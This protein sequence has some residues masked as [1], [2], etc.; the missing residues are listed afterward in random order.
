MG[1]LKHPSRTLPVAN[2]VQ[3]TKSLYGS[4][5]PVWYGRTRGPL[6]LIWTGNFQK[7]KQGKKGK[8]G[9]IYTA[10]FD[11]LLGYGPMQGIGAQFINTAYFEGFP[12]SQSFLTG[13]GTTFTFTITNTPAGWDLA[14]VIG[15][16]ASLPF[17][18][19]YN[20]YGGPG[21][22]ASS[23]NSATPLPNQLFPAPNSGDWQFGNVPYSQYNN[24]LNSPT[25]VVTFPSSVSNVN[26]TAYYLYGVREIDG[27]NS[28]LDNTIF[29]PKLGSG[30]E[31]APIVY[32]DFSGVGT[33]D[34][35]MGNAAVLPNLSYEGY[36]LFS[37]GAKG[38]A[39]PA[40]VVADLICSGNNLA[41]PI[42]NGVSVPVWQ[43][44]LNF[45]R[46]TAP[47]VA[48]QN[49]AYARY[50]GILDDEPNIWGPTFGGGSSVG[51]SLFRAFCQAYGIVISNVLTIQSPGAQVLDAI[52]ELT[53]TAACWDGAQLKIIPYCEVSQYGNGASYVSPTAS[54]PI[55]TFTDA[56]YLRDKDKN[57]K[58]PVECV[59]SRPASDFNSLT[60][61]YTDRVTGN[62]NPLSQ[63]SYNSN[64]VLVADQ[65]DITIQGPMPGTSKD[66]KWIHDID[67][68]TH[69]GQALIRR[70]VLVGRRKYTWKTSGKFGLLSLL[71]LTLLTE[72]SF[73]NSPFPVRLTKIKQNE[74]YSM[75]FEAESFIYGASAPIPIASITPASGQGTPPIDQT[76]LPGSV[77]VPIIFEAVPAI[78][79]R[80]QI[81]LCTSGASVNYGGCSIWLST[82]GGSTYVK[83]GQVTDS[84]TQGFVYSSNYPSHADPDAV[85]TLNVDLTESLG[86]MDSFSTA[87]RDA[88]LSLCYLEGGGTVNAN[89]QTLTIPYELIAYATANLSALHKYALVPTNR[90]G[91]FGTPIAAHN[92]GSDFS[93][94][95]D[96]QVFM[97]DMLQA[98]IG[99]TLHFKFTAYNPFGLMEE[100]LSVVADYTFTPTGTVG[101]TYSAGGTPVGTQPFPTGGVNPS[102]PANM[103][104]DLYCYVPGIYDPSQELTRI[105]PDRQVNFPIN[106]TASLAS[107]D[108]APTANV[109]VAINKISGGVPTQ[110]ATVSFAAAATVGTFTAASAFTINGT[111]EVITMVAPS[112]ADSTF[113]G[114]SITLWATRSN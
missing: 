76:V 59:R 35:A 114:V 27:Q 14:M 78:S 55:L 7:H 29:E 69:I 54:G 68:A 73:P 48:G 60:V 19:S 97:L 58:P 6:Q 16:T 50:G 10:N 17:S 42:W 84:N 11:F 40:D 67:V 110:V 3:V 74:D 91:C 5:I 9:I 89:G 70:N 107:C 80:P 85:N 90:R 113:A 56:D 83:I 65:G 108:V 18:V 25:I 1:F 53:L 94:L 88:F 62:R 71:D 111:G 33:I 44:G 36:G 63:G 87:Q 66:F 77:N 21:V 75:E 57:P 2:G 109:N 93:F 101:W 30:G 106:L 28:D 37:Q 15:V 47:F 61:N 49:I 38:D 51:L 39:N 64:S 20:D 102:T 31:G 72:P 45:T 96:G 12:S 86:L 92:I 34:T 105:T 82:D 22:L 81:W 52:L 41:V 46:L 100:Q 24:A 32:D 13:T 26:V 99:T 4:P 23:G 95:E 103:A 43:H 112:V 8:K 104:N 79:P 98:W